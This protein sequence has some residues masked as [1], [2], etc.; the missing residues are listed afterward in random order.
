MFVELLIAPHLNATLI[1]PHARTAAT[2]AQTSGT[3]GGGADVTNNAGTSGDGGNSQG[4][5][6]SGGNA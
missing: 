3:T 4:A 2:D 1:P 6:A 5:Q